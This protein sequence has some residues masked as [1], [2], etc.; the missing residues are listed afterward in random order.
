MIRNKAEFDRYYTIG[1]HRLYFTLLPLI[2]EVQDTEI[3]PSWKANA[4]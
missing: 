4:W 2:R 1:S 3:A